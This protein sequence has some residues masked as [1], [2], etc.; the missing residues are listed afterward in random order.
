MEKIKLILLL[1]GQD[2]EPLGVMSM[3]VPK[4]IYSDGDVREY[5]DE[6][7]VELDAFE[8]YTILTEEDAAELAHELLNPVE[9]GEEDL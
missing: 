1:Q 7:G 6:H 8:G 4:E 3:K 2:G 5:I 9:I